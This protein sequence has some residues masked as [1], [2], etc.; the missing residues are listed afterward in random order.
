M[1]I[2]SLRAAAAKLFPGAA[3]KQAKGTL[4]PTRTLT[5]T[6]TRTLTLTL[7][8]TRTRTLTHN[9]DPYQAKGMLH[10]SL[11]R[12]LSLP[13]GQHGA[14]SA[15]ARAAQ[16]VCERWSAQVNLTPPLTPTLTRH[17]LT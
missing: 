7:T 16:A 17:L 14:A 9:P 8:R 6:R 12:L 5:L 1:C 10:V 4:T 15:A 2:A 3:T 11:L 13:T